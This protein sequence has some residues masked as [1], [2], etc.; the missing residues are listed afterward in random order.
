[1]WKN[2]RTGCWLQ[3]AQNCVQATTYVSFVSP[4]AH[5][6]ASCVVV[7]SEIN[8]FFHSFIVALLL[9]FFISLF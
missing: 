7:D 6:H 5:E 3:S 4:S 8:T 9:Y 2:K 1:M